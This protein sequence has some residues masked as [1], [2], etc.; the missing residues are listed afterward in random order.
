MKLTSLILEYTGPTHTLRRWS[1]ELMAYAF[2]PVHRPAYMK[3][4]VD[5]TNRDP[6]HRIMNSY[7]AMTMS[8]REQDLVENPAA[9]CQEIFDCLI[10]TGLYS[11]KNESNTRLN[12]QSDVSLAMML[13]NGTKNVKPCA[14]SSVKSCPAN[15]VKSCITNSVKSCITIRAKSCAA[16]SGKFCKASSAKSYILINEKYC[17]TTRSEKHCAASSVKSRLT[18]SA[19]YCITRN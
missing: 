6:Y 18:D 3:K 11:V 16:S 14:A 12:P 17:E 2:K 9:Y 8:M 5:A 10:A 15:I 7:D 4:D 1:Q 19:N 13:L